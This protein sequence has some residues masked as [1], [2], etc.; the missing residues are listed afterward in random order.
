MIDEILACNLPAHLRG[1]W[2]LEAA[3]FEA[4]HRGDLQKA[5][6]HFTSIPTVKR[7]A[8]GRWKA[9]AGIAFLMGRWSEVE[10]AAGQA[11]RACDPSNPGLAIP[12]KEGLEKLIRDAR[13][14]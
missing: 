2:V 5:K 3:W 13:N 8:Y 4:R 14:P 6:Q 9:Q 1:I 7:L 12:M 11:I 10:A